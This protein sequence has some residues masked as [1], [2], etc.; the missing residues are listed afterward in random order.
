MSLCTL[1]LVCASLVT[2]GILSAQATPP[3]PGP[4]T[5]PAASISWT[6]KTVVTAGGGYSSP[7]GKF[8]YYS[9][10]H[11]VSQG[12]Y[13]TIAIEEE[14]IGGKVVQCALGGATKLLY[15]FGLFT[16]GMTGLGG[17]CGSAVAGSGQGFLDVRWG[18]LAYGN[19]VTV[20]KNTSGGWKVT[21]GFRWAQ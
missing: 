11:Y 7:N 2:Q 9:E 3:V 16:L 6:P 8:A 14:I 18:K 20:T 4:P 17:G 5:Q 15:Q 19:T 12:T 1:A 13:G 10:S 21:L